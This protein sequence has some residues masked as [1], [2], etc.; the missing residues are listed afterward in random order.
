MTESAHL[1]ISSIPSSFRKTLTPCLSAEIFP[2]LRKGSCLQHQFP[3]NM[4]PFQ[5]SFYFACLAHDIPGGSGLL[6]Q[7]PG[8]PTPRTKPLW[9]NKH[10]LSEWTESLVAMMQTLYGPR[11]AASALSH[12]AF[13]TFHS[14]LWPG[15]LKTWVSLSYV[16]VFTAPGRRSPRQTRG[17]E[18]RSQQIYALAGTQLD[19]RWRPQLPV[20]SLSRHSQP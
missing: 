7:S 9:L 19:R 13:T 18:G 10:T 12:S 6:S 1:S 20:A 16:P 2:I 17:A 4:P 14:P 11:L 8:I 5:F 3:S 15:E